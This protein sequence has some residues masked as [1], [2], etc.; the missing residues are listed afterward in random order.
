[1]DRRF[2][3]LDDGRRARSNAVDASINARVIWNAPR[4]YDGPAD[5][6]VKAFDQDAVRRQNALAK[7]DEEEAAY[8]D[9]MRNRNGGGV[10]EPAQKEPPRPPTAK[11][12]ALR[13]R[14]KTQRKGA[15]HH[16]KDRAVR[17]Q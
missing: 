6:T 17:K 4:R 11:E 12:I 1:M 3:A 13:R 9:R 2:A 14:R 10:S 8:W 16:Q 7:A 15:Q 5:P